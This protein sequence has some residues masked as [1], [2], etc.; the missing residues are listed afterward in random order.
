V[1]SNTRASV[2]AYAEAVTDGVEDEL[3]RRL[4]EAIWAQRR[5]LSG[6]YDVRGVIAEVMWPTDPMATE[7]ASCA[8]V[9]RPSGSGRPAAPRIPTAAIR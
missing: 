7:E 5:N 4:F 1:V 8:M 6:P 9:V 2:A 3:R